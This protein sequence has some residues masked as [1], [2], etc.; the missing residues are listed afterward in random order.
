MSRKKSIKKPKSIFQKTD[1][2]LHNREN[3]FFIVEG[4]DYMEPRK[5]YLYTL[6]QVSNGETKYK[7]CYQVEIADKYSQVKNAE[8]IKLIYGKG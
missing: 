1:V 2:L 7:R 3:N 4:V 5:D 8:T 6:K